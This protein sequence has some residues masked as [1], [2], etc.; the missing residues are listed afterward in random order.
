MKGWSAFCDAFF[1]V[2]FEEIEF[3]Y[4]AIYSGNFVKPTTIT[5][6]KIPNENFYKI[7]AFNQD[8]EVQP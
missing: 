4:Q 7:Y 6:A 1:G 3:A 5:A 8:E 2:K